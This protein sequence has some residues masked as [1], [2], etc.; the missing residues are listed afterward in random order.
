MHILCKK[1]TSLHN[2][3]IVESPRTRRRDSDAAPVVH[4]ISV[5]PRRP[6]PSTA[7]S[8]VKVMTEKQDFDPYARCLT[9]ERRVGA[10]TVDEMA[11]CILKRTYFQ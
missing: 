3:H 8:E 9:C 2:Y 10:H 7:K 1:S 6:S 5:H 11:H 4:L